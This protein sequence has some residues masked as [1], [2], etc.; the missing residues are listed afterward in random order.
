MT[1]P[2]FK[3]GMCTSPL[4]GEPSRDVVDYSTCLGDESVYK[5]CRFY[6]ESSPR[7]R[8]RV[9]PMGKPLLLVHS[10]STKPKSGCEF[11]FVEEHESGSYLAGC[12]VLGR[13]LT[14]YDVKLCEKHWIDCPYRKIGLR[15]KRTT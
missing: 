2:W 1:C 7:R 12:E 13:Y 9:G 4:L 15:I 11:F 3:A 5:G 10:L 8:E 6:T 14:R